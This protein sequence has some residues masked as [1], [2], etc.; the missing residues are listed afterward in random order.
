MDMDFP[1]KQF[2]IRVLS[3]RD[4]FEALK[5]DVLEGMIS[6]PR[7]L[8]PKYFYDETGS[9]L[10]DAICKTRHYYLT[11]TESALLEKHADDIMAAV[12]PQACVE[13]GAGSSV[14]TEFLLSR[15]V[16][17]S[18]QATY[19]PIDVCEEV[20][21][22]SAGRLLHRYPQ[23]HI[24]ALA[25]EYLTALR[26]LP[27]LEGPVL[28]VFIGSSI[29]NFSASESMELLSRV[30]GIMAPGDAILLGVD[31]VKN[32]EVLEQAYDDD[33]GITA[34]F[35]LNVLNVL[36]TRLQANFRLEN[37]SH[38]AVYHETKEQVEMYLVA[39][40]DQRVVLE[41]LGETLQI[42]AGEAILTEISRKYTRTTI[43]RLLAG[44]GL[45]EHSH[46]VA[47]DEYFSLVLAPAQK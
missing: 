41:G 1:H 12:Q 6:A 31:R 36:N 34:Q 5:H 9:R 29:G 18:Q 42:Q 46:F 30:A 40:Q 44:S 17:G 37:F 2:Q 45:A 16:A 26:E 8:P 33:E 13:L 4:A 24:E 7:S 10:F 32:K 39:E 20:L 23:L 21:I 27:N 19:V 28:F 14:K 47:D 22:E 15:L 38:R 43:Q 25:G 3:C 35:N 11:R